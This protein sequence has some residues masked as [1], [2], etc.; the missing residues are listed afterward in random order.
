MM[1]LA[2]GGL[3]NLYNLFKLNNLQCDNTYASFS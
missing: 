3:F 1:H 2:H